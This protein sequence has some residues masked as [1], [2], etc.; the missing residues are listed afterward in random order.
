[1]DDNDLYGEFEAVFVDKFDFPRQNGGLYS[2]GPS[3][4]YLSDQFGE[5]DDSQS[6]TDT[7]PSNSGEHDDSQSRTDNDDDDDS[8]FDDRRVDDKSKALYYSYQLDI[9]HI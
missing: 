1:M 9:W 5:D 4:D 8:E 6:R 2:A 7:L 3:R